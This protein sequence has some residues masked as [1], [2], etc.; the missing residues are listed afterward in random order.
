MLDEGDLKNMTLHK[1]RQV[2]K[3]INGIAEA[4][5]KKE[6][7]RK[8]RVA[9]GAEEPSKR[10]IRIA[11]KVEGKGLLGIDEADLPQSIF[12]EEEPKKEKAKIA[13]G[14]TREMKK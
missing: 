10:D 14:R 4:R 3:Y 9:L 12:G 11:E 6:P 5:D 2:A 8:L 7:L 1:L 13:G